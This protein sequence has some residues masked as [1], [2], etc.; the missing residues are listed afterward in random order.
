MIRSRIHPSWNQTGTKFTRY[1][2]SNPN[3]QNISKKAVIPLRKVYGPPSGYVWLDPDYSQLE[4]RIFAAVAQDE[5]MLAAFARGEDFHGYTATRMYGLPPGEITA[6]QRRYAKAVNFKIIYGGL[7][8]SP[9][10]YAQQFPRAAEFMRE[11]ERK[12]R[13]LGYVETL[14]GRRIYVDPDRPYVA[15]DAICQGTAGEIVKLAMLKLHEMEI[16]DWERDGTKLVANIH[17][18]LIFEI[19]R[20]YPIV[21]IARRIK[22]V[23]E[24]AGEE[25]GVTT[26]VDMSIV[27]SNW[28]DSEA[29]KL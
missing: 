4:L 9:P 3:G 25:L 6:E 17:D 14:G 11:C 1:S 12:V 19:P 20:S 13:E 22:K 16:V 28:S 23:M 24:L 2:S 7:K 15:V 10:E 5:G 21:P 27:T 26:P 8:N 29:L 18:Q